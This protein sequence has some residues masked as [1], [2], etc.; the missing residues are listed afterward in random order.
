[1][2]RKG[3]NIYKRKDG[4]WEGRYIKKRRIGRKSTYG[5]VYGKTYR[6]VKAKLSKKQS[7]VQL[8]LSIKGQK[9]ITF[10]NAVKLWHDAS[11]GMFKESTQIKYQNILSNYIM[12][13]FGAVK[14][15]E[16]GN[17][18][19]FTFSRNLITTG[20][21][22]KRGLSPKTVS[23]VLSIMKN[24]LRYASSIGY[25]VPNIERIFSVKRPSSPLRVLTLQEQ[26]DLCAYLRSEFLF[27]NIGILLCLFT[28]IR[29]GELCALKWEDISITEKTLYIH[30]TMQRIQTNDKMN[31]PKTKI[32]ISTP[33]S[34]CSIRTIPLPDCIIG[35]LARCV[36]SPTAFFLTGRENYFI[37]PRT[38]QNRFKRILHSCNIYPANFHSLRHTFATRCIEVGFDIKS[39][40]EILGHA[41]VNITLNRYVHPTMSLKRENMNRLNTILAVN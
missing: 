15:N 39:L 2:P 27:S 20:G 22:K 24:I 21:K 29:I 4:R 23:D 14:I 17:S 16:I 7:E 28:G 3:E 6:E 1:M 25:E 11:R 38:M 31:G 33:K 13:I 32:L 10:A 9:E 41:N 26:A 35:D 34:S 19:I 36:N 40:S 18:E 37:E 8:S 5:Y 12:P 30:R